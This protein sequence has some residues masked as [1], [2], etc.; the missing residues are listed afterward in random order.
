MLIRPSRQGGVTLV[1]LLIG[2][3]VGLIVVAGG[4]TVFTTS[5]KGQSD[6]IK[7]S[8]LN[9]DLRSMIDIMARD[10]RRAGFVTDDPVTN[11]ASLKNNPFFDDTTTGATTE[12][13]VYDS[14]NCI[15]YAYNANNDNPPVVQS[16]ERFGFRLTNGELEMRRSGDTNEDCDDGD[17]ETITEPEVEIT[18]LTF[19][20]TSTTLNATSMATDADGDGCYDG[21]DADPTTASS[22]CASGTYGNKLCDSG[23]ACN[24][25]T[26]DGSPD[27]A[28]LYVRNVTISLTGRLR[29]DPVMTQTLI[30]EVRIRNDKFLDAIP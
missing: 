11:L 27:P 22:S 1:E 7:L 4:I 14:G 10:I 17:W 19:N 6:N 28:C 18:G 2:M 26:R 16:T 24:T 20:L 21:D 3:L 8:R 13:A 25:C 9:Q 15:V 12:L 30:E 5:V 23:E 29:D